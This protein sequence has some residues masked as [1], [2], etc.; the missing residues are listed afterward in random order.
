MILGSDS[1]SEEVENFI[2]QFARKGDL[3]V[4]FEDETVAKENEELTAASREDNHGE[5]A[6]Y[7]YHFVNVICFIGVDCQ[8]EGLERECKISIKEARG[9][10]VIDQLEEDLSDEK[11][12][13]QTQ[14]IQP[15]T[16]TDSQY[17]KIKNIQD[18]FAYWML[19]E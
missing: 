18:S 19:N 1:N 13:E 14:L 17:S 4:N 3:E 9:K 5:G 16:E 12:S 11:S 7:P 6:F 10:E 8:P 15:K 2:A